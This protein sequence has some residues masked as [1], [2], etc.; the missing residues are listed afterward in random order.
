M[1]YFIQLTRHSTLNFTHI[2]FLPKKNAHETK[3]KNPSRVAR[4]SFL[5]CFFSQFYPLMTAEK[6]I[7]APCFAVFVSHVMSK[8]AQELWTVSKW[9][10]SDQKLNDSSMNRTRPVPA[11]PSCWNPGTRI[12]ESSSTPA[13]A[14]P[15]SLLTFACSH[16]PSLPR[17]TQGF[18]T[19]PA[20]P[21]PMRCYL[22]GGHKVKS[23]RGDLFSCVS[24]WDPAL[25]L[26]SA[27]AWM[28]ILEQQDPCEEKWVVGKISFSNGTDILDRA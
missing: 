7:R 28:P 25:S 13:L 12:R 10:I 6:S 3:K 18:V 20:L 26:I 2:Y 1:F 14:N 27:T 19:H 11:K 15:S 21:R 23:L 8:I 4:E 5:L 17:Y 9:C 24:P 22:E 16:I